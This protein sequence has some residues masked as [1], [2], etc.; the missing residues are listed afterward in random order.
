M[1]GVAVAVVGTVFSVVVVFARGVGTGSVVVV[2][3]DATGVGMGGAG[4]RLVH[5]RD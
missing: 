3:E 2:L 4:A 1:F 5:E